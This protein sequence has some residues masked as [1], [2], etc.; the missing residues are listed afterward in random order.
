MSKIPVAY[1]CPNGKITI[2]GES[3]QKMRLSL[4]A[5]KPK[6]LKNFSDL[7]ITVYPK[8]LTVRD[9]REATFECRARTSDNRIYPEVRWTRVG[10]PLPMNAYESGGRLTLNPVS[11]ADSGKYVCV[12]TY[13]GRSV[14]GYANLNV[15]SCKLGGG[16]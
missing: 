10:G 4:K 3:A 8:E 6:I 2:Q 5:K 16:I 1:D 9:G 7:Q 13:N 12:G 11:L 14:E 15:Q